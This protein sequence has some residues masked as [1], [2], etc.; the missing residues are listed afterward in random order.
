[1]KKE[2]L[3]ILFIHGGMTFKN[4]KDYIKFLKTRKISIEKKIK[5]SDDYL[6]KEL[7]KTFRIIKPRMPLQDN[8][9]YEE[10]KIHFITKEARSICLNEDFPLSVLK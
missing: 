3:Q 8:S 5:W 9:K 6:D 7:S 2:K 10:W 4:R 1:M